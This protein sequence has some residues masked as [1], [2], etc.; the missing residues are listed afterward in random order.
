MM[1]AGCGRPHGEG[2]S[3]MRT[4]G[5]EVKNYRVIVDVLYGRPL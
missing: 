1:Y 4:R 5:G 2:V 3:Q